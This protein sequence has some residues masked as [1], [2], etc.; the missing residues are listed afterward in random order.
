M[1]NKVDENFQWT[2]SHFKPGFKGY[3]FIIIGLSGRV[4]FGSKTQEA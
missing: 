2:I 4:V 3:I 1:N